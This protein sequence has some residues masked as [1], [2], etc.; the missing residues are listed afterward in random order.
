MAKKSHQLRINGH[1]KSG[2]ITKSMHR[3]YEKVI[4]FGILAAIVFMLVLLIIL[5]IYFCRRNY[6]KKDGTGAIHEFPNAQG[7][8]DMTNS[9]ITSRNS[10]MLQTR[11]LLN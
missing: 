9:E 1:L 2:Y 3:Q 10:S 6:K 4:L 11:S 8:H 5:T 7:G